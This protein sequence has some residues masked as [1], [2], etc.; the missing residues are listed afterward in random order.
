MGSGKTRAVVAALFVAAL[1]AIAFV[2]T[3]DGDVRPRSAEPSEH[4][5]LE[6]TAPEARALAPAPAPESPAE[7][8]AAATRADADPA[9]VPRPER[10]LL[11]GR[12]VG[13]DPADERPATVVVAAIPVEPAP[14]ELTERA[15]LV[16]PAEFE[17]DVTSLVASPFDLV[18][19]EVRVDH[20]GYLPARSRTRVVPDSK[21][22]R[23][24]V[25]LVRAGTA[26]GRVL[27]ESGSPVA[28][29][30]VAAWARE[31]DAARGPR[32]DLA[33]SSEDGTY[34]LRFADAGPIVVVAAAAGSRPEARPAELVVGEETAVP[35][36]VLRAGA[37]I[38]GRVTFA[39]GA[40]VPDL[41][42]TAARQ[43]D[44]GEALSL[45][46]YESIALRPSG[47]TRRRGAARSD[48]DGRYRIAGLEPGSHNV[49]IQ[50]SKAVLAGLLGQMKPRPVEAP[51]ETADFVLSG[52][53]VV[54]EVLSRDEPVPDVSVSVM[55]P[56][57][58]LRAQTGPDGR[59]AFRVPP[60]TKLRLNAYLEPFEPARAERLAPGEGETLFETLRFEARRATG[61]LRVGIRSSDGSSVG[62]AC[63]RLRRED[64]RPD[65]G[66]TI[67]NR[68]V[69]GGSC[70]LTGLEPG[71]FTLGVRA[72]GTVARGGYYLDAETPVVVPENG[73]AEVAVTLTPAG[74]LRVAARGADGRMLPAKARIRD[75]SGIDRP[76]R[77]VNVEPGM[78]SMVDALSSEWPAEVEDALEPGSY[79]VELSCDGYRTRVERVR[80]A[81]RETS[82]VDVTLDP[83]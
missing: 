78:W 14:S 20:P 7:P 58:S 80:I 29:A 70:V 33:K 53:S 34:R 71:R 40:P 59:A 64:A 67:A 43:G 37:T 27:D 72:G 82:D 73:E 51:C 18:D 25:R 83:L 13:L 2:L 5:P 66:W 36:H 35:D 31:S 77:F 15:K 9:P 30:T 4:A 12:L 76:V 17:A 79:E 56:F 50:P 32:L 68:S 3:R 81:A 19:L 24:D 39:D 26:A 62:R 21:E 46:G 65:G 41:V 61:T 38:E 60:E 52:A 75:A 1:G 8:E 16:S 44:E 42:V 11:E 22:Y 6:S 74:R 57:M 48:G 55:L 47:A 69:E 54:V 49:K 45:E 10:V 23:C 28:G 63:F